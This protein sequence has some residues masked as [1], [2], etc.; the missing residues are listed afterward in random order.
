VDWQLRADQALLETKYW[1]V[2]LDPR[3]P[4]AGLQ[5]NS[6][7]TQ[8]GQFLKISPKPSHS[9]KIQE[10]YVRQNDLIVR[11]EQSGD[12]LYTVQL[13]WRRLECEIPDAL[14]LE[15][16]ISVQ[17]A[18]L[19]THPVIEVRSHTP[20]AQWHG[21]NLHDLS[22]DKSDCTAIG[23]VKKSSVTAMVMIEPSDA[24]QARRIP[25]RS[26]NFTLRLLGEFMEKGVIRRARLRFFAV[27]GEFSRS[28][29]A[30]QY[31]KFTDSPL[32]LTA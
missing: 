28:K 11:Y 22:I 31:R 25:D 16:W 6:G 17:T 14:S 26:E 30:K 32:P 20:D 4:K 21:L 1:R 2:E 10:A 27:S 15:L 24:Q 8:L 3:A 12:D 7:S 19:D 18:L 23:L 5:I 9:F 13:N 29:I